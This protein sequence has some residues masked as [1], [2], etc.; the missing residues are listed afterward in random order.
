MAAK[1]DGSKKQQKSVSPEGT[2]SDL[3]P[4]DAEAEDVRGGVAIPAP[5]EVQISLNSRPQPPVNPSN[6]LPPSQQ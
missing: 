2:I 1:K 3:S 6:P 5:T 4:M